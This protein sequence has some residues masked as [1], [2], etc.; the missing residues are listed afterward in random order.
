[1]NI[2]VS[3]ATLHEDVE[4]I[5]GYVAQ[6]AGIATVDRMID[7]ITTTCQGLR[8]FLLLYV[9]DPVWHHHTKRT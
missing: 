8:T 6:T 2:R 1:M 3:S 4:A 7:A 5:Y 9:A